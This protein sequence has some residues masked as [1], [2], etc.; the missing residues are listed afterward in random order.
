[1]PGVAHPVFW[2]GAAGYVKYAFNEKYALVSRYENYD[3]HDG[4]TTGTPQHFNGVTATFQRMIAGHIL[5]RLEYR[6]DISNAPTFVKGDGL[7][8][9]GQN[10]VTAGLVFMFDSR[11]AK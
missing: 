6:R 9:T 2:T 8:V 10:T 4:F 5:S 11:E 1:M 3:D 7:P